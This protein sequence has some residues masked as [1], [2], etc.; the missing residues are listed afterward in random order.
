M[1]IKYDK[2]FDLLKIN[3]L[4][5][6]SLRRDKVIGTETLEKMRKGSGHIDSR[7][8]ERLC[9]YLNCQPGDIMEYVPDEAIERDAAK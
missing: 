3:N 4:T 7:S 8:I 6:Y 9:K 2:L 1:P 5:M